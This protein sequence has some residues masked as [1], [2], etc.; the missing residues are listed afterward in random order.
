MKVVALSVGGPREIEWNGDTVRTSIFKTPTERRLR[1]SALNIEGDEQSDLSVHGGTEK[2]VYAYP[3]EHY[4]LW[5]KDLSGADLSEAAFGE[6]LTTEGLTEEVRIGDRFR[7]GTAEFVVTQPRMPCFK[8][9]IK[10]GRQDVL[11]RMLR[12]G[13]TGFYFS[14]AVEGEIGAGDTIELVQE[15]QDELTVSDVVRLFTVE[16]K[17]QTLLRRVMRSPVLPQNWKDYFGE[18]LE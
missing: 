4:P 3:S 1:V 8:L 18:R 17:N 5:Q 15:S 13:R 10:F 14:V 16:A 9:G 6:N 12:T 7:I 11:R 2:A